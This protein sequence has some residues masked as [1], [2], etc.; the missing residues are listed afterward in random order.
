MSYSSPCK[1]E[2]VQRRAQRVQV[3]AH[4]LSDNYHNNNTSSPLPFRNP[5]FGSSKDTAYDKH[6]PLPQHSKN[7]K[8]GAFASTWCQM[9]YPLQ[10][11]LAE[12]G[13]L[14]A[15]TSEFRPSPWQQLLLFL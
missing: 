7:T 8:K 14:T 10:N 6:E 1:Q 13:G 15:P 11:P 9:C 3:L 5:T 12:G 4:A 2:Q